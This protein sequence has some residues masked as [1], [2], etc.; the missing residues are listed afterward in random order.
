MAW[1]TVSQTGTCPWGEVESWTGEV[2]DFP[3][4]SGGGVFVM[5]GTSDMTESS[6]GG[7]GSSV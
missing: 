2:D 1:G 4:G 3:G 7:R 5:S 6:V